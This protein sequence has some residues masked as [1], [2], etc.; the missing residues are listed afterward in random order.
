MNGIFN[1]VIHARMKLEALIEEYSA[2][3]HWANSRFHER[4][5]GE[6]EAVLDAPVASSFPSLRATLMHIRDA[7]AAWL[8]RLTSAAVHWPAEANMDLLTFM[9]HVSRMRDHVR[10]LNGT[11]LME[12][13]AYADLKGNRFQQPAWQ[14]LMHCFNHSSFHRGQLV[15]LMRA[16]GLGDIPRTD[17]IV[18]QRLQQPAR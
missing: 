18:F 10:S 14:M 7:E 8:A 15:T 12:E 2:Y 11:A 16:L 9:K 6:P 1:T 17:L 5:A 13:R 3:D 4:L